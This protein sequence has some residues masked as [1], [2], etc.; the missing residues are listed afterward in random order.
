MQKLTIKS[1]FLDG[2][3]FTLTGKS[4]AVMINPAAYE[5]KQSI[6][7]AKER[8]PGKAGYLPK[9]NAMNETIFFKEIV[10]DGT[11]VLTTKDVKSSIDDLRAIV[12]DYSGEKHEPPYVQLLWGNLIF[13]GCLD[14]I[15]VNYTLFKGTGEPL[16]AKVDLS[17]TRA[18]SAQEEAR[19][20]NR[21]SPDLSHRFEVRAG[22]TL[23]LLCYQVYGDSS[24]YREVATFNKLN[25]FR[26]LTPGVRLIF[27]PLV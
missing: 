13:Y 11:G 15:S 8:A 16:R 1:C 20:A 27:P 2:G 12:Y 4:W 5:H 22:D 14:T 25:H 7:R 21:S 24:Y 19:V 23:P 18:M 3:N 6:S 17:F 26:E 9:F 10:I